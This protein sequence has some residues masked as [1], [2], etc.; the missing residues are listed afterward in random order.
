VSY[1]TPPPPPPQPGGYLAPTARTPWYRKPAPLFFLFLLIAA[2]VAIPVLF[3]ALGGED[4]GTAAGTSTTG[5]AVTSTEA[6]TTSGAPAPTATTQAPTTTA[7]TQAP[8]TSGTTATT[9]TTSTTST[10]STTTTTTTTLPALQLDYLLDATYQQGLELPHGFIPDPRSW[11][12]QSGGQ[13]AVDVSYLGD[14]CVGYAN[15]APDFDLRLTGGVTLLCVYFVADNPGDDTALIINTQTNEWVCDDDTA[16]NY[17]PVV[18]IVT[19]VDGTYDIW[20]ASVRSDT[21]F[22]TGTLYVTEMD[23][24]CP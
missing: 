17:N 16:G 21:D 24:A 12:A 1:G 7:T 8:T 22:V 19:P 20:V 23:G 13:P 14:S 5:A 11:H 2:A 18:R 15:Q 3:V 4:G 6:L 10:T 9:A